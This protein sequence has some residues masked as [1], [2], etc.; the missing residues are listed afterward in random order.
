MARPVTVG[1]KK[2]RLLS[3]S[4]IINDKESAQLST[5]LTNLEIQQRKEMS[6]WEREKNKL[7]LPSIKTKSCERISSTPPASPTTSP[8]PSPVLRRR[9]SDIPAY[10]MAALIS[11]ASVTK[12]ERPR[13]VNQLSCGSEITGLR[14]SKSSQNI[15]LCA[16][17][18]SPRALGSASPKL[19]NRRSTM[20]QVSKL[21]N[22]RNTP[23]P[24]DSERRFS[25][26]LIPSIQVVDNSKSL[27]ERVKRFNESLQNFSKESNQGKNSMT[28]AEDDPLPS[29][30]L[31]IPQRP[32]PH[33]WKSLPSMFQ[34]SSSERA[35]S[36]RMTPYEDM[37]R[38][39]YLRIPDIPTLSVDQIF[40]KDAKQTAKTDGK[41]ST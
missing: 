17:P 13:G 28:V 41:Q 12:T 22:T 24:T 5:T 7:S 40:D 38:C 9:E 34:A 35:S 32:T 23:I 33:R 14:R 20:G 21:E 39:R 36:E 29:R 37:R 10:A 27:N 16:S 25:A 4:I 31:L 8:L 30:E 19:L 18:Q 2:N 1:G 26:D 3:N 11:E 15:R 6:R